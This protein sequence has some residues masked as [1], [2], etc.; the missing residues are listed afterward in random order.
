V[1]LERLSVRL[2]F[3]ADRLTIGGQPIVRVF[4]VRDIF[5]GGQPPGHRRRAYV[6]PNQPQS[7]KFLKHTLY[8][9]VFG[10]E[11]GTS[12]DGVKDIALKHQ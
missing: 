6:A 12:I 5:I 7:A 2:Y 4:S 9:N 8:S 11:E 1:L 3:L 10:T